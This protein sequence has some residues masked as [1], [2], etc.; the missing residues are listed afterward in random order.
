MRLLFD[1]EADGLLLTISKIHCIVIYNIDTNKTTQYGP[2]LIG[3]AI[4]Y[5]K[6]ADVLI[7]HNLI[8]YD[9]PALWKIKGLPFL[10]GRKF[11]KDARNG[12]QKKPFP[13]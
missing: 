2:E 7:G 8:G 1:I 6:Q 4:Q 13:H 11:R 9:L 5:L 3:E 10:K 12:N